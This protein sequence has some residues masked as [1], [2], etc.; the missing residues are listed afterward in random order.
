MEE[1]VYVS[2]LTITR[3]EK[4]SRSGAGFKWYVEFSCTAN[5]LDSNGYPKDESFPSASNLANG[6]NMLLTDSKKVK[7][8]DEF[9]SEFKE[10]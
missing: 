6:S 3:M 9:S 5:D 1:S 7:I 10:W 2:T 8:W 4:V